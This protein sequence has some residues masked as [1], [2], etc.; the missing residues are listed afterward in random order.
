MK[1]WRGF[2]LVELLVVVGI[3]AVL[4]TIGLVSYA[5]IQRD[6]NDGARKSNATIIA[7]GLERYYN[8]NGEYPSVVSLVNNTA[9][10]T[11][12]VVAAKLG[13]DQTALD[14]PN[15]AASATN[16]LTSTAASQANDY[17]NYTAS[18]PSNETSCQTTVAGGCDKFTLT[19]IEES[20]TTVTINSRH[21]V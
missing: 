11:G 18:R 20:G 21:Q 7:E 19:Y 2:T 13:I 10:N 8:K 15:M 5:V 4:A 6:A 17:I 3:I 1:D 14:M 12:T 9:G 16:A